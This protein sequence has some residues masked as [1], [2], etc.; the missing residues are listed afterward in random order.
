MDNME[1][2]MEDLRE[3]K[4]DIKE[5]IHQDVIQ[6]ELLRTH[7]ARSIALQEQTKILKEQH[8][9]SEKRVDIIWFILQAMGAVLIG[10]TIRYIPMLIVK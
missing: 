3:I 7:E 9:T 6:N 4:A 1:R 10:V 2:V 5:L 8:K